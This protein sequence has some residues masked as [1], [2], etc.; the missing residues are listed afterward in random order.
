MSKH[1]ASFTRVTNT[2]NDL[3]AMLADVASQRRDAEAIEKYAP[4]AEEQARRFGHILHQ[5][6]VHRTWGVFHH[7]KGKYAESEDHLRKALET[8][9]DLNT[10]WQI[11]RTYLELGELAETIQDAKAARFHYS[12]AL[13]AFNAMKAAPAV[14]T[15]NKRLNS[16][17]T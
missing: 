1:E 8:F 2:D 17:P 13:K 5:A 15:V 10:K 14:E 9:Q 12:E 7:I 3:Y 6:I 11:G 4:L 16:L